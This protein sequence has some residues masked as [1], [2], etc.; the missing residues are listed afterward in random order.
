MLENPRSYV[1]AKQIILD[2]VGYNCPYK[3]NMKKRNTVRAVVI[4]LLFVGGAAAFAIAKKK[5]VIFYSLLPLCL[6]AILNA[7][8]LFIIEKRTDKEILSG[9]YF[10][11]K[12]EEEIIEIATAYA[13]DNNAYELKQQ[14][15]LTG[16][17]DRQA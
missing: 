4:I 15:K 8:S 17:K 9:R 16:R 11:N 6:F 1:E 3:K 2:S 12:S 7:L 5:A 10:I 14:R 13:R